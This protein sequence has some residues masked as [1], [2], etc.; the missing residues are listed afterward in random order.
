[1][2]RLTAEVVD[3]F[4]ILNA[5]TQPHRLIE[6]L[7]IGYVETKKTSHDSSEDDDDDEKQ[8]PSPYAAAAQQQIRMTKDGFA[9][10]ASMPPAPPPKR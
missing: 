5:H 4:L 2:R 6:K 8:P 9:I 3:G 1:L 10:P 7:L